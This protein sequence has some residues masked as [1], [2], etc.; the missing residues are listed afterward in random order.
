MPARI[1]ISGKRYG[2]LIAIERIP[3]KT[4]KKNRSLWK[5]ICDCG[6]ETVVRLDMLK[7][8]NTKSCGCGMHQR[9]PISHGETACGKKSKIYSVWRAMKARCSNPNDKYF[10]N[11]GGRGIYV[12]DE[13]KHDFA[14]FKEWALNS[15]YKEGLSIDRI[16]NSFGYSPENC[17]WATRREQQQNTR[18]NVFLT[19]NGKKLC[20]AEAARQLNVH[21]ETMRHWIKKYGPDK[22]VLK[23][24]EAY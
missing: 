22:A 19:L 14:K 20:I 23:A 17:R 11:Y 18:N 4:N 21:Y 9:G 13:W 7:N 3:P 12:C 1:D 2:K 6:K 10:K 16:D 8:G 24:Q 5:C 15:G